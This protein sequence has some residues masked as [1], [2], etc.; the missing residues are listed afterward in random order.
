MDKL[1]LLRGEP[2]IVSDSIIVHQPTLGEICDYGE[3]AYWG[4]V[5][6]LT[7]TP[8]EYKVALW[9]MEIDYETVDEFDFFITLTRDLTPEQT[10]IVLGDLDLSNLDIMPLSSDDD[11]LLLYSKEQNA[12]IDKI[13]YERITSFIRE[14]NYIEKNQKRPGNL[15]T[16]KIY[17][18]TERREMERN[19]D[20]P[21]QSF[22]LPLVSSMVNLPGF[23]YDYGSVWDLPIYTF[24]NAVRRIQKIRTSD[25]LALGV[26]TGKIEGAKVKKELNWLGEL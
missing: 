15:I 11:A 4:L 3:E 18:E 17:I 21:F 12:Y 14:V 2:L 8:F 22:L 5:R 16:K 20:K 1:K 19:K 10:R 24:L 26:Y 13:V 25:N 7:S 23:K 6:K 9:D